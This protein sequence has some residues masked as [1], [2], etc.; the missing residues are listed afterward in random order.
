MLC[1][2]RY[3]LHIPSNIFST[4]IIPEDNLFRVSSSNS[5]TDSDILALTSPSLTNINPKIILRPITPV[6]RIED[7]N[8]LSIL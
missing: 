4:Q 3:A 7:D 5:F 2:A 8:L 6:Q 1:K